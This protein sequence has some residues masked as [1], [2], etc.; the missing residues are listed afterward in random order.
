MKPVSIVFSKKIWVI[1]FLTLISVFLLYVFVPWFT[2]TSIKDSTKIYD[3]SGSLLYEVHSPMAT[4]RES[5]AF[6]DI[7]KPLL[8]AL[9]SSEDKNFYSHHGVDIEAIARAIVQNISSGHVESGAST[10]TSQLVK[11]LYYANA[12]RSLLE[13]IRETVASPVYELFH[14]KTEILEQ[15]LNHVYFGNKSYGIVSAAQTYFDKSPSMLSIGECAYLIGLIPSPENYNPFKYPSRAEQRQAEVLDRMEKLGFITSEEEQEV[16]SVHITP[17]KSSQT[18]EAAHF[19]DYVIQELKP[20]YPDLE[21]GGYK[22]TTTLNLAWQR[23][24]E[25]V[26]KKQIEALHDRHLSNGALIAIEPNTGKIRTMVGSKDYEAEDIDGKFNVTLAKRQPGSTLKPFTYLTYFMQGANP[27]DIA[28][29]IESDFTTDSGEKYSPKNYDLKYHGP[30]SLGTALG[31][32]LNIIAVQ[33]LHTVGFSAFYDTLDRF[34]IHFEKDPTYYGLGITLGGGEVRLLDLAHAYSMLAN[35][36]SKTPVQFIE[37]IEKDGIMLDMAKNSSGSLFP[38]KAELASKSI[39]LLNHVL[40]DNEARILSFGTA[41]RLNISE[42]IAVKTG[43][44]KDFRD[45]WALGYTPQLTVGVWVGNNDN[46]PMEGVSGITGAIPIWSDFIRRR[47]EELST[48]RE[49]DWKRP[50][51]I[52]EAQVCSLSGLLATSLCPE[53]QTALFIKEYMPTIQDTWYKNVSID[54]ATGLLAN[55]SCQQHVIEKPMLKLPAALLDW[56]HSVHMTLT[57]TTY[58][59]GTKQHSIETSPLITHPKEQDTFFI[60]TKRPLIGQDIPI[61]ITGNGTVTS[62]LLIDGQEVVAKNFSAPFV[63]FMKPSVGDH[64]IQIGTTSRHFSIKESL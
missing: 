46:T 13:K 23:D 26:I 3:K 6:R 38:E 45:N 42:Y 15:Y 27:S 5:I 12:D 36:G 41:N 40:R 61:K 25:M 24:A 48:L 2:S 53:Q 20:T 64:V 39:Y 17:S 18:R 9:I 33:V 19:V 43:T 49:A 29:D 28:Y 31:S 59:D 11:Q 14:S 21:A 37:S 4:S 56:A 7:P 57:P 47:K 8:E 10:I 44:T 35:G 32:S 54:S 55:E 60:D 51:G 52:V 16:L 1:F 50:A 30:V 63:F 58:C 62:P 22:I 34:G